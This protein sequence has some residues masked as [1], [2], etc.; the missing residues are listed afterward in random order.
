VRQH[1]LI[2]TKKISSSSMTTTL[3]H[4]HTHTHTPRVIL[5]DEGFVV[6]CS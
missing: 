3:K 4:T 1:A 6:E 5:T 2:L